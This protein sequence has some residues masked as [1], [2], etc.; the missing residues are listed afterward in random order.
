M[1]WRVLVYSAQKKISYPSGTIYP[2]V[3]VVVVV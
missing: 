1:I 3:V 2:Q